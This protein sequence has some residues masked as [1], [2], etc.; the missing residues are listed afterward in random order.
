MRSRWIELRG[1][2]SGK[3]EEMSAELEHAEQVMLLHEKQNFAADK[4]PKHHHQ[5]EK[6]HTDPSQEKYSSLY[7]SFDE[8]KPL[9]DLPPSLHKVFLYYVDV[10]IMSVKKYNKVLTNLFSKLVSPNNVCILYYLIKC[11]HI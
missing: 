5:K 4:H 10:D 2:F 8:L 7:S 11:V 1:L 3:A 6:E 9:G